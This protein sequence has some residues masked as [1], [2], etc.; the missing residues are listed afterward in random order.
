ML[1]SHPLP[2][3]VR[4]GHRC[5][6]W[7]PHPEAAPLGMWTAVPAPCPHVIIFCSSLIHLQRLRSDW[8]GHPRD[9]FHLNCL[10]QHAPSFTRPS[11]GTHTVE[12]TVPAISRCLV[13]RHRALA[14]LCATHRP[15]QDSPL[16]PL[17]L[18]PKNQPSRLPGSHH[19][20]C[21]RNIPVCFLDDGS[22]SAC[23][24]LTSLET[25]L[26][27]CIVTAVISACIKKPVK[28][29]ALVQPF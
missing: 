24:S 11:V 8:P 14:Q 9:A 20:L 17:G 10:F 18:L 4:P 15:L 7:S 6:V 29:G 27:D 28:M 23:S 13:R 22:R 5:G 16:P 12:L 25:V 3:A 19:A 21:R 2:G 1:T 26:L